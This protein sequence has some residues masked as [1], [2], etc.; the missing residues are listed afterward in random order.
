[1]K[2][3]TV[4]K[5][6]GWVCLALLVFLGAALYQW[7]AGELPASDAAGILFIIVITSV[8]CVSWVRGRSRMR[9]ID[10]QARMFHKRG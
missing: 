4:S 10:Y 1:M 5:I 7:S 9:A 6:K 3:E 8:I 2:A